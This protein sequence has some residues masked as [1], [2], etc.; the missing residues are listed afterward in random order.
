MPSCQPSC[1]TEATLHK[2]A[3]LL[4]CHSDQNTDQSTFKV[5]RFIEAHSFGGLGAGDRGPPDP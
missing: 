1:Q 4:F 2:C 3:W 5:E